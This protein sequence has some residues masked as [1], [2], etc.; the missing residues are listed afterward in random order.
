MAFPPAF[1]RVEACGFNATPPEFT[2]DLCPLSAADHSSGEARSFL[3]AAV[4]PRVPNAAALEAPSLSDRVMAAQASL[5]LDRALIYQLYVLYLYS[6]KQRAQ[7]QA[8]IRELQVHL[9]VEMGKVTPGGSFR[10][11]SPAVCPCPI[12]WTPSAGRGSLDRVRGS[13]HE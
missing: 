7:M 8:Q 11:S 12:S 6:V 10:V 13:L 5:A 4:L 9:S 1:A 2:R 3:A